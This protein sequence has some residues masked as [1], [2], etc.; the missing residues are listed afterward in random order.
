MDALSSD[1]QGWDGCV[2]MRI[3]EVEYMQLLL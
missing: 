1:W 3:P 2:L